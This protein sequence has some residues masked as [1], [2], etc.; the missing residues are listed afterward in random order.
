MK[1][2]KCNK[3]FD[4]LQESHN[5]PCYMFDEPT[6]RLRKQRADKYGRKMLCKKCHD[7]YEKILFAYVFR[8]L[9]LNQR[10]RLRG[11]AERFSKKYF[12]GEVYGDSKTT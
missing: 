11:V 2:A 10:M 8:S 7:I 6:R 12:E 4:E 5:V 1:C 9:D 3:E